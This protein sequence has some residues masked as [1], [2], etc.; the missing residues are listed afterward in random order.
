M[1]PPLVLALLLLVT[2]ARLLLAADWELD[3]RL[4]VRRR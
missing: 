2:L 1:T 3:L 4:L